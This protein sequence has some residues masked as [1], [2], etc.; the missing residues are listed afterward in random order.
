MKKAAGFTLV[1]IIVVIGVLSIVFFLGLEVVTSFQQAMSKQ[2]VRAM[3]T[4]FQTAARMAREGRSGTAWGVYVPYDETSRRTK[5]VII[6]SG[7][8]YDTRD[9]TRDLNYPIS[10][11]IEFVSFKSDPV[12][13]GND[14]EILFYAL[15]GEVVAPASITVDCYENSMLISISTSGIVVSEPL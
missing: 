5:E 10:R 7:N 12:S 6:F 13:G 4:V 15:S 11:D 8:S 3:E 2:S 14:H 9:L 1:E